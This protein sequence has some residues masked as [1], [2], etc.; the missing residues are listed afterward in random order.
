VIVT[1]FA[2]AVIAITG[3]RHTS[4]VRHYSLAALIAVECGVFALDTALIDDLDARQHRP[5]RGGDCYS[6]CGLGALRGI[7][8]R[9]EVLTEALHGG[10]RGIIGEWT[11]AAVA[12]SV[13][14]FYAQL[15]GSS[16]VRA[17]P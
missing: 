1:A 13:L 3:G 15:A 10:L 11:L 14:A 8:Q 17:W 4:A 12:A 7:R 5:S 16:S 2:L 9:A 6:A